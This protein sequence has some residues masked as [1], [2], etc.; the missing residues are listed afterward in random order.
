MKNDTTFVRMRSGENG[1]KTNP[2]GFWEYAAKAL[3]H[4]T[5][6]TGEPQ[7]GQPKEW[8]ARALYIIIIPVYP[9]NNEILG[10][11]SHLI[12]Y[13]HSR[14]IFS[15]IALCGGQYWSFFKE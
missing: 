4:A 11:K 5:G 15:C 12:T 9:R 3:K 6:D 10:I 7:D 1:T 14:A 8:T 13:N 2:Q